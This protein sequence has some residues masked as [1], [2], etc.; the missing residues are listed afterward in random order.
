MN[1]IQLNIKNLTHLWATAG[2]SF[3]NYIEAQPI[4]IS[5]ID[6]SQWPNRIWTNALLSEESI[7]K[8]ISTMQTHDGLTFSYFNTTST[9]HPLLTGNSFMLKSL[10]YGMSMELTDKFE[11]QKSITLKKVTNKTDS[12]LWSK[13]FYNAFNYHI[14]PE[15]VLKT[16]HVVPYFIAFYKNECIGT[17]ILHVTN[18]VLGIHSLGIIP[19]QRKQ[20]FALEI[21]HHAINNAI[22]HNLS[23]VILQASQ[24]AKDMYQKIG[25]SIDFLME[26]YQ[27]KQ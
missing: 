19:K 5:K 26:N 10:Q 1:T 8:I 25:F 12:V 15:V 21:M 14:S 18:N 3:Q 27:L 4:Y 2:Q 16:I 22:N 17:V 13:A 20:G 11:T 7:E 9:Q 6:G 24:M 23:I